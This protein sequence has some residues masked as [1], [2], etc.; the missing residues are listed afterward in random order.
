MSENA[1]VQTLPVPRVEVVRWVPVLHIEGAPS[2]GRIDTSTFERLPGTFLTPGEA[3][4]VSKAALDHRAD[5]IGV[6]AQRVAMSVIAG[7]DGRETEEMQ[8]VVHG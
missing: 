4:A 2:P 5:A 1:P 8:G 6:S 3:M 7:D